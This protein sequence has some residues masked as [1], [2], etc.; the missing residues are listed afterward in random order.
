MNTTPVTH[1]I[2]VNRPSARMKR[3]HPFSVAVLLMALISGFIVDAQAID[4]Q[5]IDTQAVDS[6]TANNEGAD[7]TGLKTRIE[8]PHFAESVTFY[9]TLLGMQVLDTWDDDGD[10]GAILG[11]SDS[12]GGTAF[13]ELAYS[14]VE[15]D[16]AG[17]SL[18]FR[19]ADI[20]AVV[21]KLRGQWE[22][23]GPVERPWGSTYLYLQDPAGVDVI[24]YAGEL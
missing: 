1:E 22:Y 17:L 20:E 15:H 11:L 10:K 19:V 6:Q 2:T 12:T 13:L 3:L 9:T 8:T 5:A 23:R 7:I 14:N 24:V 16:H 4:T 21:E 18:Q